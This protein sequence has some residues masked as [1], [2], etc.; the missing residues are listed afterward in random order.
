V[1]GEHEGHDVR[2]RVINPVLLDS[3]P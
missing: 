2:W 3:I 1:F